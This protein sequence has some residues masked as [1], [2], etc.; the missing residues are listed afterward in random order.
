[1]TQKT[2]SGR[3]KYISIIISVAVLLLT[4]APWLKIPAVNALMELVS[5]SEFVSEYLLRDL[6]KGSFSLW[7]VIPIFGQISDSDIAI[8]G[9]RSDVVFT[10]F[11]WGAISFA[12]VNII[13]II[14][15]LCSKK[16]GT[17]LCTFTMVCCIFYCLCYVLS[18]WGFNR[19]LYDGS[20]YVLKNIFSM[21]LMP[22]IEILLLVIMRYFRIPT[23]QMVIMGQTASAESV[24][25]VE[26]KKESRFCPACGTENKTEARFCQNCGTGMGKKT[27]VCTNCN[28]ILEENAA[29]CINC[30]TKVEKNM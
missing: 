22:F 15:S 24:A 19:V 27:S 10:L 18:V 29:F 4:F 30:G 6:M 21:T 20:S 28:T 5:G 23:E 13:Y 12:V 8:L 14:V 7:E 26:E 17:S 11:G 25:Q 1:M 16:D 9:I 2:L 3:S